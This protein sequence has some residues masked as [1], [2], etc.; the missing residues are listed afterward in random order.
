M[1]YTYNMKCGFVTILGRPNVGKST[2]LN[3]ILGQKI[4]IATD[5][6]Q[7]TRKRIKGILTDDKGQVIFVDTPGVHRPLN[8]LG[9]FLLDEAKIAVP[10]ADLILFL[11]DGTEPAGKGDKWIVEN[12]LKKTKI[13]VILVMNKVDKVKKIQKIEE[14]LLSYKT[15]FNENVPIVKISAK[16]GR[17]KD[18]LLTNIYKK[19]PEGEKLYPDDV[20]TEESMRSVTEEII[21][22]K[23]LIHTQDEIPHSVA[24]KVEKYE[25]QEDIDRIF[26]IIYCE[27]KSQKGILIG[28][29]GELLKKIGTEAR[30]E[31]EEMLEKKVYL[32]LEV[33]V[34]KDWRKKDNIL[35]NFGFKQEDK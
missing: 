33:K 32:K 25:E 3:Q 31:L 20:V 5:K 17:N 29:G 9:E 24:I 14:N 27:Q 7:T 6:A 16:T 19:L 15:L 12:I 8:K 1:K 13:P 28:K 4:V 35:K 26:A 10:D 30:L 22:E 11:V 2:L 23:I 34:E 21:R 18:T